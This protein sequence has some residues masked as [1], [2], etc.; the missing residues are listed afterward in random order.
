MPEAVSGN[1][2]EGLRLYRERGCGLCH[3]LGVEGG[4]VGPDLTGLARRME[5]AYL[6]QHLLDPRLARPA[7]P[8]PRYDWTEEELGHMA[9]YVLSSPERRQ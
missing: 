1:P 5:P 7:A 3:Q 8:E 2:R 4:A 6:R 9:A